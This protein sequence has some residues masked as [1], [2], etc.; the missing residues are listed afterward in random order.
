LDK[1][2]EMYRLNHYSLPMESWMVLKC[3]CE[4]IF[5]DTTNPTEERLLASL[6]IALA[7]H[8]MTVIH[9]RKPLF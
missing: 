5:A 9:D 7:E 1:L 4:K 3:K 2:V 8:K 6:V